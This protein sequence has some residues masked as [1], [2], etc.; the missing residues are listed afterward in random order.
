LNTPLLIG[1]A[2]AWFVS[3]RSKDEKLNNARTQR[4]TLIASGFIAGGAL[5]GVVNAFLKFIDQQ[6][7]FGYTAWFNSAW[8]ESSNGEITGLIMFL[9]LCG[10]ALWDSM[11]GKKE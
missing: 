8:A 4:G 11:R 5:L 6:A 1:G 9:L 10:Y 3:S 2:I 7:P